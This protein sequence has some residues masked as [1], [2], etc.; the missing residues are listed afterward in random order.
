[1]QQVTYRIE[2]ITEADYG[3]EERPE[4]AP[5]MCCLALS[6]AGR[7]ERIDGSED[8]NGDLGSGNSDDRRICREVVYRTVP[9]ELANELYLEKGQILTEEELRELQAGRKPEGWDDIRHR[10][11]YQTDIGPVCM[12]AAEYRTYREMKEEKGTYR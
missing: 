9:D 8:G 1:M 3:C 11:T 7:T 6:E 10:N 2:D 5:L 4:G 12:S